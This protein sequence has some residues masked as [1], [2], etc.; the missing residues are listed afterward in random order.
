MA[1]LGCHFR[2]LWL[3]L[4]SELP[5]ICNF[6]LPAVPRPVRAVATVGVPKS[7]LLSA[8]RRPHLLP[9]PLA[10]SEKAVRLS[11]FPWA[12]LS[13]VTWERTGDACICPGGGCVKEETACRVDGCPRGCSGRGTCVGGVCHCPSGWTGEDCGRAPCRDCICD[14]GNSFLRFG[15]TLCRRLLWPTSPP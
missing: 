7:L 13:G 10:C 1:V 2:S 6:W 3:L 5:Y 14:G 8:D 12:T 15:T 4:G 11:R 9:F